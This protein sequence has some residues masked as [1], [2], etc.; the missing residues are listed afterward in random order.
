[1]SDRWVRATTVFRA[2]V[3]EIKVE[4]ITFMAGSIAYNAFVSLL[5][6]LFLLLTLISFLGDQRL[7]DGFVQLTRALVTPDVADL[8]VSELQ[9]APT[10]AS[11]IGIAALSWGML[12]IFRSL[13]M[14][15]SNIYETTARNTIR[16]QLHDGALAFLSI[17]AVLL[18]VL[19]VKSVL[20][21]TP[22]GGGSW[23]V[24]RAG[25]VAVLGLALIPMYYLFPDEPDLR[26]VETVPGVVVAAVGLVGFESLFGIYMAYGGPSVDHNILAGVLVFL[27]WLYFCALIILLGVV[28]NA[29]VTNRS[30]DVSI[31]PLIGGPSTGSDAARSDD[32]YSIPL[33]SLDKL[34][35]QLSEADEVAVSIDGDTPITLPAPDLTTYDSHSSE[36]AIVIDKAALELQWSGT[37]LGR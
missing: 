6:L 16:N 28:V 4:R 26:V 33:D 17:C 20:P 30:E 19:A 15:F 25:L 8:V 35:R 9:A 14:A 7:E 31:E 5:P 32:A 34:H 36:S 23:L 3:H 1:M 18:G 22:A 13:D 10:G 24:Q 29:V 37:Q 27:A 2:I 11:I 12:R 21:G